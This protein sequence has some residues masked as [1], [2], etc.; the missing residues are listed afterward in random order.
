MCPICYASYAQRQGAWRH[1]RTVHNPKRCFMCE[2]RYAR[3]YDYWNHIKKQH[4]GVDP[5]LIL[6]KAPW[7]RRGATIITEH[8]PQQMSDSSAHP[9]G[10]TATHSLSN[11]ETAPIST[12]FPLVG[13]NYG[14]FVPEDPMIGSFGPIRYY[15]PI[16]DADIDAAFNT[17]FTNSTF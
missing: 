14:G 9:G 1:I 8:L 10:S 5:Y 12:P 3:P 15:S 7:S 6:G 2:F 16:S 17:I 4:P 13:E 11:Q